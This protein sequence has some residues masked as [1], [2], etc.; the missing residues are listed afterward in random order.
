MALLLL[1][2]AIKETKSTFTVLRGDVQ[3]SEDDWP[4]LLD[5]G[6]SDR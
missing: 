1:Q 5:S 3:P 4:I 6:D 2:A